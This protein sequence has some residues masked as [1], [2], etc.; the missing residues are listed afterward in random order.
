M[1][2]ITKHITSCYSF[3]I[4]TLPRLLFL[5]SDYL[6]EL[7][8]M[9]PIFT[10]WSTSEPELSPILLSIAAAIE[11]TTQAQQHV[12]V[13]FTPNMAQVSMWLM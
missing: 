8:Q 2:Y 12:L 4:V 11:Q 13:M 9:H 3:H 6:Y 1:F 5:S 10:L 7:Q